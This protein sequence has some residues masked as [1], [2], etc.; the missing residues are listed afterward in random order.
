MFYSPFGGGAHLN[1]IYTLLH[2][3][4]S[5]TF[6]K[7]LCMSSSHCSIISENVYFSLT[8]GLYFVIEYR[9][10]ILNSNFPA[11]FED[12]GTLSYSILSILKQLF[13]L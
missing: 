9:H 12:V 7:G 10:R 6:A 8:L 4:V 1:L 13:L 2:P 11:H 3:L 5:N